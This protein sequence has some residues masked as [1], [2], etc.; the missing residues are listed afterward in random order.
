MQDD[1]DKNNTNEESGD[2]NQP[3]IADETQ[4]KDNNFPAYKESSKS[5]NAD[6]DEA[7]SR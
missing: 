7:A 4:E 5:S 2:K 6:D 3:R 1:G